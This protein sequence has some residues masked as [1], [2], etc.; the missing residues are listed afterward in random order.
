MIK[1]TINFAVLL[2]IIFIYGQEIC[3]E[4]NLIHISSSCV[5]DSCKSDEESHEH[6]SSFKIYPNSFQKKLEKRK[7]FVELSFFQHVIN[8]EPAFY[9]ISN[10]FYSAL[11]SKILTFFTT[12]ILRC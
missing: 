7:V 5:A 2:V 11:D 12:Q 6:L 3:F 1:K 9:K 8:N 10:Y 4:N